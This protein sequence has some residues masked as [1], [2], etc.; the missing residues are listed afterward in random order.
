MDPSS[1]Y[2]KGIFFD[3]DATNINGAQGVGKMC[4]TD[5]TCIKINDKPYKEIPWNEEPLK[6]YITDNIAPDNT[7]L[8]YQMSF[9]HIKGD[10]L[11]VTC[12]IQE[13]EIAIFKEW[14]RDTAE[15]EKRVAVFDWDKTIS[16]FE[17]VFLLGDTD[18][19]TVFDI[20][21]FLI[22]KIPDTEELLRSLPELNAEDILV[23]LLGGSARLEQLRD[24]FRMCQTNNI[25][26][27]ILTN[28]TSS[29]KLAF[30]DM[31]DHLF[32]DISYKV[33]TS[34]TNPIKN[35]GKGTYLKNEKGFEKLC[36]LSAPAAAPAPAGPA[37]ASKQRLS[38]GK[39]Y[40][41]KKKTKKKNKK[42]GK[43]PKKENIRKSKK[44]KKNIKKKI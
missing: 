37:A 30:A 10:A 3:N 31:L 9:A 18:A 32:Q 39:K 17:G 5:M 26:I 25:A 23:Y 12:G 34:S 11:D 33:I 41:K 20:K 24:L 19:P 4:N 40:K 8:N 2:E 6:S 21:S 14:M 42:P 38:A 1:A 44:T 7:Y 16:M 27:I 36:N 22:Q 29:K 15:F 43:K 13:K 35:I 28:N